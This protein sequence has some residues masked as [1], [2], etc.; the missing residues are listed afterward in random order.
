MMSAVSDAPVP[1][2]CMLELD[3]DIR[4]F[5]SVWDNCDL[6]STYV[7][8]MVST[9]RTDSLLFA[10]LYSSALNE[11]LETVYRVHGPQGVLVCR[12]FRD[13]LADRIEVDMPADET[14]WGFYETAVALAQTDNARDQYLKCLFETEG[15][16]P[17]L[18]ILE[19]A[20]NY[21]ARLELRKDTT[22]QRI[23]ILAD[24]K[25]EDAPA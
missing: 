19:L 9:N 17:S 18:G 13:G 14:V 23:Q 1:P 16:D 7:S 6:M 20:L 21:G 4:E 22:N 25:I 5:S 24:L 8:K 15:L 12:F 10:N 11:L 3:V 2:N